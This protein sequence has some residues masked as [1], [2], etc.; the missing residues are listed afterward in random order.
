MSTLVGL[1]GTSKAFRNKIF[2]E[3]RLFFPVEILEQESG[4]VQ[5]SRTGPYKN[6]TFWRRPRTLRNTPG[7]ILLVATTPL[8]DL[9]SNKPD[10]RETALWIDTLIRNRACQVFIMQTSLNSLAAGDGL[11]KSVFQAH[12]TAQYLELGIITKTDALEQHCT[13]VEGAIRAQTEHICMT[14]HKIDVRAVMVK[15]NV[16]EGTLTLCSS[17][18][19]RNASS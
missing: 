17:C 4:I 16:G 14:C 2:D 18:G 5:M 9:S 3:R 11:L 6:N 7:S 8:Q 1:V 15:Q 12:K 10:L 13:C 19:S